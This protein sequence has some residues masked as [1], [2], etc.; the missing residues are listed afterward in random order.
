MAATLY[1]FPL[2]GRGE[3]I[4]LIAAAGGVELIANDGKGIDKAEFGSPSGLPVLQH[5]DLK[6]SQSGAIEAYMCQLAFPDLA[7]HQRAKDFQMCCIK[8]DA[9]S[10]IASLVFN[11]AM[12]EKL[13]EEIPKVANKW[14]PVIEKMIPEDGFFNGLPYPTAADLVVLNICRGFMPFGAGAKMAGVDLTAAY[15]KMLAHAA[16]VAEAPNIKAYLA[17]TTY[18]AANPLGF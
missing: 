7:P 3:T 1:Y 11:P 10:G 6:M 16:R 4:R 2:A 18:M 14:Y 8:E 12:K 13:A 17:S 15:P 9:L 5:G